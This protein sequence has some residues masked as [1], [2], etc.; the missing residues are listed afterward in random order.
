MSMIFL[1]P[2]GPPASIGDDTFW[3][4]AD[5]EFPR[6]TLHR[7]SVYPDDA[8]VLVYSMCGARVP[9]GGIKIACCW[10][11]Y[12]EMFHFMGDKGAEGAVK[13]THQCV[14]ACHVMS[15]HNRFSQEYYNSKFPDRKPIDR[16]L[17]LAVDTVRFRPM[18]PMEC[19]IK[20]G[21][22]LG[23]TVG[24][25]SGTTHPMKG[26]DMLE[27]YAAENPDI[28]WIV[29][30]KQPSDRGDARKIKGKQY[31][32]VPQH[33]L[34]ELMNCADFAL[35][36]GR[37]RPYVIVEW[38][39]MACNLPVIDVTGIE[40]EFVPSE[41]PRNDVF[42]HRWDRETAKGDWLEFIEAARSEV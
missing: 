31:C 7:P 22:P 42:K 5:R 17:P 21:I 20:H 14:E 23:D 28:Y 35:F 3:T 41:E 12:P 4:W 2:N 27:K 8:V 29:G 10:E 15:T 38:E 25:W 26:Y 9:P 39:A 24:F 30:W 40:R 32:K 16:L 37:L 11:L 13:V 6:S 34:A 1:H 36:G 18:D 33:Q 19:R